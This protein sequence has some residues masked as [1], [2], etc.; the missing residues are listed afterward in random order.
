MNVN[1]NMKETM[2]VTMK[3]DYESKFEYEWYGA[4]TR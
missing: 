2:N 1:V 3:C 4:V